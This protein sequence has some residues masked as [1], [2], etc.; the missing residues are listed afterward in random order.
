MVP[1][2]CASIACWMSWPSATVT[3][4]VQG[5]S[6]AA[7]ELGSARLGPRATVKIMIIVRVHPWNL[8]D[9][10]RK[11]VNIRTPRSRIQ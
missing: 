9:D 8:D 11:S 1:V 2:P 3:P 5:S 6:A 7:A 10:P 4:P